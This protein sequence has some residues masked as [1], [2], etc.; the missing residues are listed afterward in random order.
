MPATYYKSIRC[1]IILTGPAWAGRDLE[2]ISERLIPPSIILAGLGRIHP[3]LIHGRLDVELP[4]DTPQYS[5]GAGLCALF[6]GSR[7]LHGALG[8]LIIRPGAES[9]V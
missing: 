1:K 4:K 5:Q 9:H 8:G 6:E 7:P 2:P 3:K